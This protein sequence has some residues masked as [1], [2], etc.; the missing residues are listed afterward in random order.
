VP[1]SLA[2]TNERSDS[3]ILTKKECAELLKVTPR[4]IERAVMAGRLR[5]FKPTPGIFRVRRGDLM[6]FLESGSSL[7][8]A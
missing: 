8:G 5:A 1:T 2:L 3:E 4:Y 6:A 7:A